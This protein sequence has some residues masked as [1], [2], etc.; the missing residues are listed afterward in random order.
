[1]QEDKRERKFREGTDYNTEKSRIIIE[2]RAAD[3]DTEDSGS[4]AF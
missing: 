1:L 4:Q 2:R 3:R